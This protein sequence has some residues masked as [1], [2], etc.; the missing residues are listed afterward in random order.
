MINKPL[1]FSNK[2]LYTFST[3]FMS[4]GLDS[5]GCACAC[6]C[7]IGYDRNVCVNGEICVSCR[8]QSHCRPDTLFKGLTHI[9]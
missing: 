9:T 8:P 3:P 2:Q 4:N 1:P 5:G 7:V 6:V